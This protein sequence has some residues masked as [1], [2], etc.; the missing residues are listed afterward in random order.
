MYTDSAIDLCMAFYCKKDAHIGESYLR[1][2]VCKS[3]E[4]L[5]LAKSR[6]GKVKVLDQKH[7]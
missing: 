1:F 3:E 4:A 6:L 5:E 2:G 7:D